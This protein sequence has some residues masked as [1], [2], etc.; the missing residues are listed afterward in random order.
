MTNGTVQGK[1]NGGRGRSALIRQFLLAAAE[2]HDR[3]VTDTTAQ[4]YESALADIPESDLRR[5]LNLTLDRVKFWPTPAH[6]REQLEQANSAHRKSAA[7]A[8]WHLVRQRFEEWHYDPGMDGGPWAPVMQSFRPPEGYRGRV[9]EYAGGFLVYPEPL[10]AAVEYAVRHVGGWD[11]LKALDDKAHD[12]VRRDFCAAVE[13][14]ET[15]QLGPG[16]SEARERI[17]GGFDVDGE[18]RA[19][20]ADLVSRF[21]S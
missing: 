1:P 10:P 6:I 12:F 11:R 14:A 17:H 4:V 3:D 9:V 13:H 7:E 20:P 2:I 5:A 8:A 15:A 21:V 19:L 18:R 16:E